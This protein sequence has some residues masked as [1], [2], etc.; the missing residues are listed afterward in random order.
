MTRSNWNTQPATGEWNTATNWTPPEV[1][2]GKATFTRSSQTSISF[3][4]TAE[5]TVANIEFAEDASAYTFV[6][7]PSNTP[8]LTISGEGVINHSYSQ[9]SFIVAAT[10][11][12]YTDPQLKFT[13]SATAGGDNVF[14]CAGPTTEQGSGGGVICFCDHSTAGSASFKVWTGAGAPPEHSTVGGEVSFCNESSA[15]TASFT[16]YGTLGTDGDTFG[17]VVFHNTAT[18]DNAAFTNIGGTVSGGD[19]GNTQFYGDSTA[20]YGLFNNRG[21]TCNKANGGDVAFDATANGGHGHF[22]NHAA[23]AAGAYGGVTSF[24]NNPPSMTLQ[25]A[26]AG[27]G[28]YFNYGAREGEEGGGGHIEFSAKYGSP[29]A[30]NGCFVNYGS[31]IESKSSAGHTIF[32]I[33]L[34]TDYYPTAG[35]AAF[36]NHPG[37]TEGAAAGYTEFSVYSNESQADSSG[38]SGSTGGSNVPTAG[39]GTFFNL[40][41]YSPK[42]TGGYTV[43]SGTSSAG[44]ATLIAY[45]G[46]NGGYGGRIV[47]YGESSGGAANVQ[48]FGNGELD[49]SD[50]TG[51]VTIGALEMTG[52]VIVTQLGNSVTRLTVSG[53]LTLKSTDVSFSFWTSDSAGFEFNRA[54]TILSTSNLSGLSAGHF[55]GNSLEGVEPTFSIV[56]DDL[57]VTFVKS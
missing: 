21:G 31:A 29:T 14:Y 27:H 34:P 28:S 54:Y 52:G 50:H 16:I 41:G 36:W 12:G 4:A 26:S 43:F 17:N 37:V 15:G 3:S 40:G 51:G 6:F 7:G 1:P 56:G 9:Q 5:A 46:S 10:S 35:N 13:N 2:S 30:A 57:Q 44:S 18:A 53:E 45:G 25:G 11:S 23:K 38:A 22:Y 49:I 19:G 8:S 47:F 55:S 48:L 39:E 32:S 42:A 33:N 20:A 24:N